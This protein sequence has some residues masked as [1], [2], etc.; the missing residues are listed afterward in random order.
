MEHRPILIDANMYLRLYVGDAN[1]LKILEKLKEIKGL[2]FVSE[3][4]AVEVRRNAVKVTVD[5]LAGFKNESLRVKAPFNASQEVAVKDALAAFDAAAGN[6]IFQVNDYVEKHVEDVMQGKDKVSLALEELLQNPA[7]PSEQHL[8]KARCRRERGN[9]PGKKGDPL[10]DQLTW[11]QFTDQ[12]VAA[13][14]LHH[15]IVVSADSDFAMKFG[16]KR[17]LHRPL[18]EEL[19]ANGGAGATI[20][21]FDDFLPMLDAVSTLKLHALNTAGIATIR[22]LSLYASPSSYALGPCPICGAPIVTE[23]AQ[24]MTPDGLMFGRLCLNGHRFPTDFID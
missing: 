15:V 1:S 21:V 22:P 24:M 14:D 9:P 5:H 12:L 10:G 3:Q 23:D 20:H 11:E 4:L 8:S 16:D 7:L 6:A 17:V 18:L 13:A 2:I 19:K